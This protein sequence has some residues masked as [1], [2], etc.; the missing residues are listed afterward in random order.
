M[1]LESV[2]ADVGG[3]QC[4]GRVRD[5][6]DQMDD[7]IYGGQGNELGDALHHCTPVNVTS[8]LSVAAFVE[9]Q[10]EFIHQFLNVYQ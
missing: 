5:L 10:I 3:E 7:M 6:F 8:D 2:I 1:H 4:A 9:N